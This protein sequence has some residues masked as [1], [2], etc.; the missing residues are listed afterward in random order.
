[1][2]L[3][4]FCHEFFVAQSLTIIQMPL[5]SG[6]KYAKMADLFDRVTNDATINMK[7]L[8]V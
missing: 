1:M 5:S 8:T 7:F 6:V 2:H 3:S 4:L